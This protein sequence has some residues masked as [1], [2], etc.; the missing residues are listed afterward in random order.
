M[1]GVFIGGMM[2]E[3]AVSGELRRVALIPKT[4]MGTYLPRD[5]QTHGQKHTDTHTNNYQTYVV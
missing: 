4:P 3:M 5:T 1:R 2:T